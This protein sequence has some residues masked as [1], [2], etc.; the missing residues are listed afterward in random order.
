MKQLKWCA[1]SAAVPLPCWNNMV[2]YRI[3]YTCEQPEFQAALHVLRKRQSSLVMIAYNQACKHK[4]DFSEQDF[5]NAVKVL[6]NLE[7]DPWLVSCAYKEARRLYRLRGGK[8]IIF[9]GKQ[10]WLNYLHGKID[11]EACKRNR[12]LPLLSLGEAKEKGNCLFSVALENN[13][14]L[15]QNYRLKLP[16]LRRG[17]MEQLAHAQNGASLREFPVTFKITDKYVE[18]SFSPKKELA[19]NLQSSRVL[20]IEVTQ[21]KIGWSVIDFAKSKEGHVVRAGVIDRR[22]LEAKLAGKEEGYAACRRNQEIIRAAR[23]LVDVAKV[24][25]CQTISNFNAPVKHALL[26]RAI[27]RRCEINGITILRPA[28]NTE[29][30][31]NNVVVGDPAVARAVSAA[32]VAYLSFSQFASEK[33]SNSVKSDCDG[34]RDRWNEIASLS[35]VDWAEVSGVLKTLGCRY[36]RSLKSRAR[37]VYTFCSQKPAFWYRFVV[38]A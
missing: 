14:V 1:D 32:Q 15:F 4:G 6:S 20:G 29:E 21:D 5:K 27:S 24:H 11:L 37:S 33:Q 9:G 3:S 2:T 16:K 25:G 19:Q 23:H 12:L 28:T 17:L 13:S 26:M 31:N 36:Q 7:V 18:I 22:P 38:G 10:N 35:R 30:I 8:S 34:L